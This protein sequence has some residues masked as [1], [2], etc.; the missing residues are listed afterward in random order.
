MKSPLELLKQRPFTALFTTQF[1]G[2]FNDNLFKTAL[3]L[4]LTFNPQVSMPIAKLFDMP[5]EIVI[6]QLNAAAGALFILPFFIFSAIAG[7]VADK[8]SKDR[9]VHQVKLAEIAIMAIAAIGFMALSPYLLLLCLFAMGTQSTFFG[10]TKYSLL[11]E[12]LTSKTLL[13]GNALVQAA[14]FVAILLG[15]ILGGVLIA[16]QSGAGKVSIGIV[17]FAVLGW[18][19]SLFIGRRK[20]ANKDLK[21]DWNIARGTYKLMRYSLAKPVIGPAMLGLSWFWLTGMAMITLMPLITKNILGGDEYVSV[22]LLAVATLGASIGSLACNKLLKGKVSFSL[23]PY[24]AALMALML[25]SLSVLP[26]QLSDTV[27]LG[28]FLLSINGWVVMLIIM[29][30]AIGGGMFAVPLFVLLQAH[31]HDD[32]RSQ[33]IAAAN[34]LNALFMVIGNVVLGAVMTAGVN[35]LGCLAGL[36]I[37]N[38]LVAFAC[39]W[40]NLRF[41]KQKI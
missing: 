19:A 9:V 12:I 6:R 21:I 39:Y 36:A 35:E 31:S 32:E 8:Y 10:P 16:S 23:A 38:G 20:A 40:L 24:G 1:F 28:A 26:Q 29:A 18:L 5:V 41:N 22:T 34:V 37:T 33:I 14:T 7:E 4:L 30:F 13:G 17:I 2:A 25:L 3:V 11:P 27:S 15:S